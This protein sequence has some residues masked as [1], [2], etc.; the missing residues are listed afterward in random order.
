[1]FFSSVTLALLVAFQAFCFC[2]AFYRLIRAF[3]T[4][5]NIETDSK[6]AAV[7][8]KGIGWINGGI[9]LGA[10]ETVVGFVFG[11]V[12]IA[13]ARRGLRMLSRALLCIG[14]AKGCVVPSSHKGVETNTEFL[15]KHSVDA[16][17]DFTEIQNELESNSSHKE[18]RRSRL[19]ELISNPRLSTFR[20]LSPTA[21]AFHATP[22]APPLTSYAKKAVTD[23]RRHPYA[24]SDL[25][26]AEKSRGN[27]YARSPILD[28]EKSNLPSPGSP[29]AFAV[30]PKPVTT[31]GLPG[32]VEFARVKAQRMSQHSSKRV[33]VHYN[34]GTPELHLRLSVTELPSPAVIA[35]SIKSRPATELVEEYRKSQMRTPKSQLKERSRFSA[36]SRGSSV[37]ERGFDEMISVY[38]AS[39]TH[40]HTIESENLYRY[41]ANPYGYISTPSSQASDLTP[42]GSTVPPTSAAH[43][44]SPATS[45]PSSF[46]NLARP[47]PAY[48]DY[49]TPT[50]R[51]SGHSEASN[52]SAAQAEIVDMPR[53]KLSFSKHRSTLARAVL[54]P[55]PG[56]N[57][58]LA[59][60][61]SG[62]TPTPVTLQKRTQNPKPAPPTSNKTVYPAL[63]TSQR[64][65][66]S[67]TPTR[68]SPLPRPLPV[69]QAPVPRPSQSQPRESVVRES[70]VDDDGNV[71]TVTA[72]APSPDEEY[73]S[74]DKPK[75][76]TRAL[77]G[78]SVRSVPETLQAVRELA[79]KFPGLP[80]GAVVADIGIRAGGMVPVKEGDEVSSSGHGREESVSRNVSSI[81]HGYVS[82]AES[83]D[84]EELIRRRIPA[85]VKMKGKMVSEAPSVPLPPVPVQQP[86]LRLLPV[87]PPKNPQRF[88]PPQSKSAQNG[89]TQVQVPT[90]FTAKPIDP[91]D[92]DGDDT[93]S[94]RGTSTELSPLSM[95]IKL[96][97]PQSFVSTMYQPSTRRNSGMVTT[98]TSPTSPS[99]LSHYSQSSFDH[100][101]GQGHGRRSQEGE[102]SPGIVDFGTALNEW[103]LGGH[104]MIRGHRRS[105]S[106]QT[107]SEFDRQQKQGRRRDSISG[108]DFDVSDE[109]P[110]Q[111]HQLQRVTNAT[112][113]QIGRI[114]S[115]GKAPRRVT[116]QPIRGHFVRG[117]MHLQPLVIPVSSSSGR[118]VPISAVDAGG[119]HTIL[120]VNRAGM[121][122]AIGREQEQ[123][124]GEFVF[125]ATTEG[126]T[127]SY[128]T[129]SNG[130][131]VTR[132]SEVLS[133]ADGGYVPIKFQGSRNGSY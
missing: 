118:D 5:R 60:S 70:I 127:S 13:Y 34:H 42:H 59:L 95:S 77:S 7:L 89:L 116:P 24:A 48:L 43:G 69:S 29:L 124:D 115:I 50:R 86:Q 22:R 79:K 10:I 61:G 129:S 76:S 131:G 128:G 35:E 97:H 25:F 122:V 9:K 36:T 113:T 31:T 32:M 30:S 73:D 4:Q 49:D 84:T 55:V 104:A 80:P 82:H 53:R 45:S 1:M 103:N 96:R 17:E 15:M 98:L 120:G 3:L 18:F 19:R 54:Y 40:G 58:A 33:T 81:G 83:T 6:D 123:D 64:P 106:A 85:E 21:T 14:V 2:F 65:S 132:Y 107:R 78:Y 94:R 92:D 27:L 75:R 121:N 100:G 119:V 57:V 56:T 39:T 8:F 111:L 105:L 87:I 62:N 133:I 114:K 46:H 66:P 99:S 23:R 72:I 109:L 44:H 117:S 51:F 125:S 88:Q 126:A 130:R 67:P 11:G 90:Q 93:T 63:P 38:P 108:P 110:D 12:Q 52:I 74:D 16:T 91:F 71:I 47:T 68:Q 41:G 101:R 112:G 37:D 20:P 28:A 102:L 26:S